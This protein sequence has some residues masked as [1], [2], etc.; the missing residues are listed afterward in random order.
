MQPVTTRPELSGTFGAVASTSLDSICSRDETIG[1][2]GQL[3]LMP[4][5]PAASFF[6]SLSP[7]SMG[8]EAMYQFFSVEEMT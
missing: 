1:N 5:S 2:G 4:P 3:P 7:I 8:R 6:K